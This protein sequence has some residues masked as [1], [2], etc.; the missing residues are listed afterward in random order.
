MLRLPNE[1]CLVVAV[2]AVELKLLVTLR[3]FSFSSQE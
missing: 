2:D 3:N 1:S